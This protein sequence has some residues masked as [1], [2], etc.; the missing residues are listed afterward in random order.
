MQP[1]QPQPPQTQNSFQNVD[2]G[3]KVEFECIVIG[4][5]TLK[6]FESYVVT[7]KQLDNLLF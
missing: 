3:D 6:V 7:H 1:P 2:Y 4:K 5:F